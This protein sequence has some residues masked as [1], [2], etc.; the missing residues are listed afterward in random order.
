M[1]ATSSSHVVGR[2]SSGRGCLGGLPRLRLLAMIFPLTSSSPPHTPQGSRRP[3]AAARQASRTSHP[4]QNALARA[5]SSSCSE[6]NRGV[7]EAPLSRQRASRRHGSSLSQSSKANIACSSLLFLVAAGGRW[8]L[9]D[10]VL[11]C[12][13]AAGWSRGTGLWSVITGRNGVTT[14][15]EPFAM[16]HAYADRARVDPVPAW[17]LVIGL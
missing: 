12:R 11:R 4:A 14:D 7:S 16:A 6:K 5:M 1:S 10:L 9:V 8:R 3:T 17:R 15:H 13:K 2:A